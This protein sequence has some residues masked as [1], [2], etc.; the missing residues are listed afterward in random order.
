MDNGLSIKIVIT[1]LGYMIS[2]INSKKQIPH[3]LVVIK[4]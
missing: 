4:Y 3:K 2:K 1:N